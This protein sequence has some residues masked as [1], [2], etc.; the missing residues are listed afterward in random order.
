[1]PLLSDQ[2]MTPNNHMKSR[3]KKQSSFSCELSLKGFMVSISGLQ[4]FMPQLKRAEPLLWGFH[5]LQK[6]WEM[7]GYLASLITGTKAKREEPK[8]EAVGVRVKPTSVD[9]VLGGRTADCTLR[10]SLWSC[11]LGLYH[12][13]ELCCSLAWSLPEEALQIN[14]LAS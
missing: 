8:K 14:L 5:S 10:Q 12:L 4:G 6:C 3:T 13:A 11:R 1:M 7:A 9:G 2:T